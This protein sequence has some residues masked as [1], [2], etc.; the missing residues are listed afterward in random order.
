MG[1]HLYEEN[2]R[3]KAENDG[4]RQQLRESGRLADEDQIDVLAREALKQILTGKAMLVTTAGNVPG[5]R[6]TYFQLQSTA[7]LEPG[8]CLCGAAPVNSAGRCATCEDEQ[9]F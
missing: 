2:K 8:T 3:L 6:L 7:A 9:P 1:H 5:D 4:L